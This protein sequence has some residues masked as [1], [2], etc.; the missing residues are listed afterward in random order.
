MIERVKK[1]H[2]HNTWYYW[3]K[4]YTFII[5]CMLT[6]VFSEINHECGFRQLTSYMKW[7]FIYLHLHVV[8]DFKQVL[9]ILVR[10]VSESLCRFLL[11]PSFIQY[12]EVGS[13]SFRLICI[14]ILPILISTIPKSEQSQRKFLYYIKIFRT[15]KKTEKNKNTIFMMIFSLKLLNK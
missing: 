2:V 4:Q 5:F 3:N 14:I 6:E 7:S 1:W 9:A 15:S 8:D 11:H 12:I 10:N 13:V